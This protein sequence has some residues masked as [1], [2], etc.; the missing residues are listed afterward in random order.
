MTLIELFLIATGVS[1]DAFA[2]AVCKGL[3]LS[4]MSWKHA[5]VIGIYFGGFQSAMP[6]LGYILG[7]QF[8]DVI[9][10]FDQWIIFIL[11]AGI[12]INMM[13]ESFCSDLEDCVNCS[14]EPGQ[15]I[16]LALATSIDALAVGVTFSFL[17]VHIISSIF[18]I[19]LTSFLFSVLGVKIGNL[20][21]I[22]FKS[23]AEFFGGAILILMGTKILLEQTLWG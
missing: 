4:K 19:G 1:M 22:R 13:K 15:M 6:F 16:M 20:F 17:K 14:L 10:V 18:I 8:K 5:L 7:S 23:K 11:L 9:A 2:V 21:G 3:S 12:G